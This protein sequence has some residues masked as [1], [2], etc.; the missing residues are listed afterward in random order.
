MLHENMDEAFIV[1]SIIS[2]IFGLI[3]LE[4]LSHNWFKKERFKLQV[5]NLKKQNDLQIK[6]MTRDL[7]LNTSNKAITPAIS[8]GS[9][10]DLAKGLN[11]EQISGIIAALTGN[12][13]G[14][15]SPQE[16]EEGEDDNG[17]NNL[18]EFARKN[19]EMVKGFLSKAIPNQEGE[20]G[21]QDGWL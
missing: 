4:L 20:S 10:L 16:Y 18:I 2:G 11:P 5:F 14:S 19:P 13:G 3:G 7:G 17:I 9:I 12:N 21:S 6:K 15:S 1:V 8:T